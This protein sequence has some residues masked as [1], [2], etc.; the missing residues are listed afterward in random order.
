M[1]V[2]DLSMVII[3]VSSVKDSQMWYRDVLGL[4][5]RAAG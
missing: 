3:Y 2:T 5:G 4:Y 1:V